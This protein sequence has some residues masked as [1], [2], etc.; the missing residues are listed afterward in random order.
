MRPKGAG[1]SLSARKGEYSVFF[2][3]RFLRESASKQNLN[4]ESFWKVTNVDSYAIADN[5]QK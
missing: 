1:K 4:Y 5:P 3:C 2:A